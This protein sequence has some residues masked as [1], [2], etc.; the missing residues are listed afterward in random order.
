T[1]STWIESLMIFAAAYLIGRLIH[2]EAIP[3]I[4]QFWITRPYRWRSLLMAKLLFIFAFVNIPVLLAQLVILLIAGFS[5]HAILPGLLWCQFLL[6]AGVALPVT[7]VASLTPGTVA[8]I[9]TAAILLAIGL[10][11]S[12]V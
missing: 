8:F 12:T 2:A 5:L 11:I 10:N 1:S 3:G 6:F 9:F 4:R 7:A